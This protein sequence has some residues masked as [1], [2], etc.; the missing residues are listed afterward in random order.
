MDRGR[1]FFFAQPVVCDRGRDLAKTWYV[2][3]EWAWE[4]EEVRRVRV[5]SGAKF[6]VVGKGN[7][8]ET[9]KER[10]EYF[11]RLAEVLAGMLRRGDN[12]F[13][14][15][16]PTALPVRLSDGLALVLAD[17][18]GVL[19]D[20]AHDVL[21]YMVRRVL[22]QWAADT[23][24]RDVDTAQVRKFLAGLP[25]GPSTYNRNRRDMHRLWAEMVKHG[26][27]AENIVKGIEKRKAVPKAHEAYSA[28][29]MAQIF[30]AVEAKSKN[31][32]LC[33]RLMFHAFLRPHR[34]CRLIQRK[35]IDFERGVVSVPASIRKGD[36]AFILPMHPDL[37]RALRSHGVAEL[38]PN[39]YLIHADDPAQSVGPDYFKVLWKRAKPEL[40]AAGILRKEQTLYSI[41]HTA[42]C[43]YYVKTKDPEELQRLMGHKDLETT[44]IYLRSLGIYTKPIEVGNL[45]AL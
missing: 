19:C 27:A 26:I 13:V 24:V 2:S 8:A 14:Q 17:K 9:L 23:R 25:G 32:Y 11:A 21:R 30:E 20:D 42:A 22:K 31:L 16:E 28:A 43:M 41:R 7:R 38:S 44:L 3:V 35:H 34:E 29:Q 45:P 39:D 33:A 36:D 15:V 12:P 4:G 1:Q 5:Y 10:R 40:I 6:G 37:V 18:K